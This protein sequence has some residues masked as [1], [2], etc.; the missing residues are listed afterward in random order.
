MLGEVGGRRGRGPGRRRPRGAQAGR[1]R[2][3][4]RGLR[5]SAH[6]RSRRHRAGGGAQAAPPQ[7]QVIVVTAHDDAALRA[8]EAQVLDYVLKPARL[9]RVRTAVG[10][11]AAALRKAPARGPG[12]P[13]RGR[14]RARQGGVVR[15][16]RGAPRRRVRG[17]RGG[18]RHLLRDE[19]RAGVGG[20]RQRPPGPRSHH[21]Q[22][23]TAPVRERVFPLPPRGAWFGSTRS[24]RWSRPARA[25]T[26]SCSTI[27]I[28]RECRWPG[29]GPVC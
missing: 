11:R 7:L 20:D 14:A 8:F 10:A 21:D 5:R 2:R 28:L 23:R 17:A 16:P 26:S 6:A 27:R 25:P 3:S 15:A 22:P 29:N 9:E 19:G 1:A 13:T 24:G 18:R 4:R 12:R